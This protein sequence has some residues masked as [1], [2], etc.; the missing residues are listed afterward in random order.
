M[1][2]ICAHFLADLLL[3]SYKGNIMTSLSNDI[4]AD[5]IEDFSPNFQIFGRS[6]EFL[7]S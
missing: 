4:Q 5:I 6:L 7:Q 3:F 2:T 1:G